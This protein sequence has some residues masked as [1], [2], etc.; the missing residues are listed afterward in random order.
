LSKCQ[1]HIKNFNDSCVNCKLEYLEFKGVSSFNKQIQEKRRL[2][3][4]IINVLQ[5][6]G[7][8]IDPYLH[9]L[10]DTKNIY[11]NIQRHSKIEQLTIHKKFLLDNIKLVK[12][13]SIN[14][15]KI[16]PR[17]ILL[18][19]VEIQ[20]G[21][22]EEKIFKWWNFIWWSIPYQH[23]YGRQLRFLLWDETHNAP[24][25]LISLQSPVLKMG[26]RD[27]FL[28][29]PNDEL[30]IWVN[31]S[32]NAQR[33]GALPPY[34]EIIGGKMVALAM[35]SNEV[36]QIYKRKYKNSLTLLKKRNIKSDLLFLTTTSAFGKSSIYDRLK[37]YD[38]IVAK[39]LGYTQ[40]SGSFHLPEAIYLE[41]LKFLEKK[42]TNIVRHYGNGPSRKLKLLDK[43]LS[44]LDLDNF[45]FHG[46]KREFY[47]FPLVKNLKEVIHNRQKPQWYDRPLPKLLEFWKT[48]WALPRSQA[49]DNWKNFQSEIF[50]NKA[51]ND[52]VTL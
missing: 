28:E 46:I 52:L 48:R 13:F 19:L 25:G 43:A 34:N 20:E 42:G 39:S 32:M 31:R 8:R 27:K 26:V 49:M 50:F 6:Q 7:F 44:M 22:K 45:T 5:Q 16:D 21:S 33:V 9:P 2:R 1:V 36:R 24:F 17:N 15:D 30:D 29:I 14:G 11:K 40:G 41:L 47:I 35:T 18:K 12:E 38:E 23:P 4:K 37:F 10:R 51:E 3:N